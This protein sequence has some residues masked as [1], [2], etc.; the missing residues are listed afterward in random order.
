M[1]KFAKQ[2]RITRKFS[3]GSAAS[4]SQ[5]LVPEPSDDSFKDPKVIEVDKEI[6]DLQ[7]KLRR[8]RD[9]KKKILKGIRDSKKEEGQEKWR[10]ANKGR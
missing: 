7:S 3:K 8:L 1:K 4:R 2:K 10:R 9:K 5:R 6:R